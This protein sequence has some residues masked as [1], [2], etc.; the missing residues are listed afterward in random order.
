MNIS[1]LAIG[2]LI[3]CA[4]FIIWRCKRNAKTNSD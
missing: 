2:A 1:I 4:L 3:D